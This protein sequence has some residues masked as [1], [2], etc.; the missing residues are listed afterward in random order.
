VKLSARTGPILLACVA[1]GACG[2]GGAGRTVAKADLIAKADAICSEQNRQI[3]A[4]PSPTG[5]LANI[6]QTQLSAAASYF[7]RTLAI[8]RGHLDQIQALGRPDRDQGLYR[9]A[10]AQE[11]VALNGVSRASRAAHAGD[12][13]GFMKALADA[14]HGA[15][16]ARDLAQRFGFRVCGTGAS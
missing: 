7:D 6:S 10:L 4:V 16:A 12:V 15:S 3:N 5:S 13:A 9:Q 14:G 11:Q 2:G 8:A 1:L